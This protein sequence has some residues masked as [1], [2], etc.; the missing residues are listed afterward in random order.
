M[1]FPSKLKIALNGIWQ[2]LFGFSEETLFPDFDGFARA[3][4][5][6]RVFPRDFPL[7]AN[8]RA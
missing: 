4:A 5:V 3:H 2:D 1:S 8:P 6:G 7:G